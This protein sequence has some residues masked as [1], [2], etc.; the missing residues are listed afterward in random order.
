MKQRRALKYHKLCFVFLFFPKSGYI[1]D[2]MKSLFMFPQQNKNPHVLRIR[3]HLRLWGENLN[4]LNGFWKMRNFFLFQV[5]GNSDKVSYPHKIFLERRSIPLNCWR[6]QDLFLKQKKM[7]RENVKLFCCT[8]STHIE[9]ILAH[10]H[11]CKKQT[12]FFRYAFGPSQQSLC[13]VC[14]LTF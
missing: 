10:F 7:R 4:A 2:D 1:C 13:L 9:P 6:R 5:F 11:L 14:P 3:Q 12:G 8:D